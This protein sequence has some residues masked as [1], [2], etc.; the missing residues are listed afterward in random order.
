MR[1][2][3]NPQYQE[4]WRYDTDD[5]ALPCEENYEFSQDEDTYKHT[6]FCGNC[7]N[8]IQIVIKKGVLIR[9]VKNAQKCEIICHHC[10]V[11]NIDLL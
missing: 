2:T 8:E 9:D 1:N 7:K 3:F 11:S 4:H 5:K 6:F 10:G